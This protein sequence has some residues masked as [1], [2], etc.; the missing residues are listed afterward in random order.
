MLGLSSDLARRIEERTGGNPLFAVQL[1]RAWVQQGLLAV[2][3]EGIDDAGVV[4]L[5]QGGGTPA[6]D[7][8]ALVQTVDYF[9]PVVDDPYY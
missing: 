3:P 8:V 7:D 4:A 2:G 9:P 5:G 6:A 1:V